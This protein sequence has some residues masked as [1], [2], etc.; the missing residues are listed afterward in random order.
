MPMSTERALVTPDE[1]EVANWMDYL[2]LIRTEN[3]KTKG[4]SL[5][6]KGIYMYAG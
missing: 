2:P 3:E 4:A 5:S 6:K 1:I